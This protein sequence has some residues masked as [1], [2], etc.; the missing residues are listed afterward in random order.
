MKCTHDFSLM[1]D[2]GWVCINCGEPMPETN[3][4]AAKKTYSAVFNIN[5]EYK[6]KAKSAKEA[7]KKAKEFMA[8]NAQLPENYVSDSVEFVMVTEED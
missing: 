3:R 4:K 5:I 8:N 6:I 2:G 7:E 1:V